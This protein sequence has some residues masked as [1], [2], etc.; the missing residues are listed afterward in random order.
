MLDFEKEISVEYNETRIPPSLRVRYLLDAILLNMIT[1]AF[2]DR[3]QKDA[4]RLLGNHSRN[5]LTAI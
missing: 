2:V 3:L 4:S 1:T 5:L